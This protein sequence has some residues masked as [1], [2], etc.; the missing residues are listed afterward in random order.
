[1]TKDFLIEVGG[2]QIPVTQSQDKLTINGRKADVSLVKLGPKL[3]SLL[4][5]NSSHVIHIANQTD[6]C[7]TLTVDGQTH[8]ANFVSERSKLITRYGQQKTVQKT[9][10]ELRAPMLGLVTQVLVNPGDRVVP[11][12]GLVVLE[13]MK[14]ENELRS[15]IDGRVGQVFVQEGES[16]TV[17]AILVEFES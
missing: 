10:T 5:G 14:M 17:N 3:Y 11:G 12:Q 7:I 4:L 8:V 9:T 1:M 6:T 2:E 13:A 16:V 15:P